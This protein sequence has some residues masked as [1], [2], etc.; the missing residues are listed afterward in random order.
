[1]SN[2]G[3]V[4]AFRRYGA[5]QANPQWAVTVIAEDGSLV[6]SCWQ[7]LFRRPSRDVMRYEDRL[8]TFG[9]NV[10]GC[11]LAR[12]HL[13]L[14]LRDSLPVRVVIAT[15]SDPAAVDAGRSGSDQA[16]E[17][18][19]REDLLGRVVEFDGDRFVIDFR[20]SAAGANS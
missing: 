9:H 4:D 10:A 3:I 15:S 1:M 12:E 17:F 8:S 2:L 6:I 14:A 7:H 11:N 18:H 16:N 5:K 13:V 20:R 19:V